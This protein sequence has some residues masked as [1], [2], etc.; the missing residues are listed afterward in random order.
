MRGSFFISSFRG[1]V[2]KERRRITL[3]RKLQTPKGALRKRCHV[4]PVETYSV[5]TSTSSV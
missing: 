3:I 5:D 1:G 2:L 4:E